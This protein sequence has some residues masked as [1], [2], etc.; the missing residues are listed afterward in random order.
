MPDM[1]SG[2]LP[3]VDNNVNTT[4]CM[5][6]MASSNLREVDDNVSTTHC[7]PDMFLIHPISPRLITMA[8]QPMSGFV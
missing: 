3:E 5:P 4:H 1:S 6:D 2:N 7:T 8:A